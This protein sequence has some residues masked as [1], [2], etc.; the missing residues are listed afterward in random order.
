MEND[1]I[2][3]FVNLRPVL[4]GHVLVCPKRYAPLVRDLESHEMFEVFKAG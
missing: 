4:P 1:F 3:A 2:V